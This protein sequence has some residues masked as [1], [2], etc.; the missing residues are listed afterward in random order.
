LFLGLVTALGVAEHTLKPFF[1]KHYVPEYINS[2]RAGGGQDPKLGSDM[3]RL[4]PFLK[5]EKGDVYVVIFDGCADCSASIQDDVRSLISLVEDYQDTCLVVV[6]D[7]RSRKIFE[8]L[9]SD[10][11]E[12]VTLLES[13]RATGFSLAFSPKLYIIDERK[14]LKY[15]QVLPIPI[16]EYGDFLEVMRQ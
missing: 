7:G 13:N 2:E 11:K 9:W 15:V 3:S 8:E 14:L 12:A 6:H 4:L 10:H 16:R 1:L 5:D